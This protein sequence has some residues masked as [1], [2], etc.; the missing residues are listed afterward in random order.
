[1]ITVTEASQK[2]GC[3]GQAVRDAIRQGLLDSE[4]FGRTFAVKVNKKYQEWEPMPVRQKAA[5]IRWKK[6]DA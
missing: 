1:M 4:R 3:S 5:N 6:Q 2:K